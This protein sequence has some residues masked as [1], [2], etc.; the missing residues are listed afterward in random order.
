MALDADKRWQLDP[1]DKAEWEAWLQEQRKT[2]NV[3]SGNLYLQVHMPAH[4]VNCC[5]LGQ[6]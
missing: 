4:A 5:R 6:S 2:A 1:H 3:K